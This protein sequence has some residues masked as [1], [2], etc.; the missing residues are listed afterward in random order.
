MATLVFGVWNGLNYIRVSASNN[1]S[2]SQ[3]SYSW[4]NLLLLMGVAVTHLGGR[5]LWTWS[6]GETSVA[7]ANVLG[8]LTPL[9]ATLGGW[10]LFQQS[11]DRRFLI[12]MVLALVGAIALGLEDFFAVGGS[13]IEDS[14]ALLSSFFYA[15]TFLI[16]ERLWNNFPVEIILLWRCLFGSLLMVPVV[17]Y[18]SDRLFPT[19]LSGWL[20]IIALAVICEA[21]GH[22]LVVYSLKHFSASFVSLVLLLDPV[23][24][25]ILAWILFLERLS[26]LNL[27]AFVVIMLG[28]YLAKTGKGSDKQ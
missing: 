16:L 25:A 18:F 6:L 1:T 10:L 2:R 14:A 12:G 5:F 19:S 11:F 27:L 4:I 21:V 23:V 3:L 24:A 22:G 9:F 20:A 17:L 15:T 26:L 13:L 7:N 28:I 8:A